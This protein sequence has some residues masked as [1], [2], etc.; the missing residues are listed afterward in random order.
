[1]TRLLPSAPAFDP[2][3]PH[4]YFIPPP[5]PYAYN[6]L[7]N[8][9]VPVGTPAVPPILTIVASMALRK[10]IHTGMMDVH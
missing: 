1:M 2:P 5:M 3:T 4:S 8:T 6:M 7:H 9:L 10:P